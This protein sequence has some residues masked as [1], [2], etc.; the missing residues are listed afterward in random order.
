MLKIIIPLAGSSELFSKAG[1]FYPKPLIEVLGK[2]MIEMVLENPLSLKKDIQFIFIIKEEDAAKFHLDST[3]KILS[4]QSKIIKLS[5]DTKGG[6]CSV[7]MAID[8]IHENDEVLILNGD[9]LIDENLKII[10]GYWLTN[11]AEAGLVSFKSVH[12]RWAYARI[13]GGV[14][15]QTAEKNPI[16]NH[17][18][19]GVY[20]FK[21][22][23][24][25]FKAAFSAIKN[26]VQLDGMYYISPVINEY[27]LNS[28]KVVTYTI[29]S[30]QYH[31][32][33]SPQ[34]LQDYERNII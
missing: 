6:L 12:P 8:D 4:P 18:L 10:Y 26:G 30:N 16:S 34:V 19:A 21:K 22:A 9:Q 3:L 33:Y 5:H 7:L 1:Y 11:S 24:T 20:Y 15:V 2:P 27:V 31:L 13:E 32:F 14:V 29:E 17:A 28:Q 23:A 25:F